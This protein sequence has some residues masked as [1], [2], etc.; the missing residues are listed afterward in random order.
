MKLL[1][2]S[3]NRLLEITQKIF[4]SQQQDVQLAIEE[5]SKTTQ[6]AENL[7]LNL[8]IIQSLANKQAEEIAALKKVQKRIKIASYVELG[9]GVPCMVLSFLPIWT[10]EQKNIQNLLLGIGLTG[11]AAGVVTFSFTIPF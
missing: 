7:K 8:N 6:Q 9:V 1:L 3:Y 11:T 5:I 10:D 2:A 4:S